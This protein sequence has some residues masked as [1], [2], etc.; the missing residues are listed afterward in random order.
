MFF[1]FRSDELCKAIFVQ[2]SLISL[3]AI[4][5]SI[6]VYLPYSSKYELIFLF[7]RLAVMLING[8]AVLMMLFYEG[9]FFKK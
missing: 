7:F 6:R 3:W 1:L 8:S 9:L 4:V 2:S 5:Y